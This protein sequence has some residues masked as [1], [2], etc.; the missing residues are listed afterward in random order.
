MNFI[1]FWCTVNVPIT[2]RLSSEVCIFHEHDRGKQ[3]LFQKYAQHALVR[4]TQHPPRLWNWV[5]LNIWRLNKILTENEAVLPRLK[6]SQPQITWLFDSEFKLQLF[7]KSVSKSIFLLVFT[8]LINT[9]FKQ[10]PYMTIASKPALNLISW[11][12]SRLKQ[13]ILSCSKRMLLNPLITQSTWIP[14]LLGPHLQ[15]V[16]PDRAGYGNGS[17]SEQE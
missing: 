15:S 5:V 6:F 8:E 12:N 17:K 10:H 1:F 13:A 2:A 14:Y 3:F 7:R 9:L 4:R 16:Q 11:R